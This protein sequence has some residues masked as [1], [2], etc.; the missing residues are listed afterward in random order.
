M[1]KKIITSILTGCLFV[2]GFW[3]C[4][5]NNE[6]T[7]SAGAPMTIDNFTPTEG[8]GTTEMLIT[9]SNFSA[10]SAKIKVTINGLPLAIVAVNGNQVMAVVPKRCGSGHVVVSIGN[11]SVVS[12]GIFNYKFLRKV[13][14]LA[15][16]GKAGFQNAQGTDAQFDFSS[17]AWYRSLGL[18]VDDNLNVYLADPGNH[19]IRKIDSLGNV[20]TLAGNP[21]SSGYADGQG[22]AAKF[23]IPYDVT[24]D[25]EGNVW[26]ADP[27]NWDIRKISPDGTATTWAWATQDPWAVAFDKT[28]GFVYYTG[29]NSPG[30]IYQ[31]TAQWTSTEVV[32]GLNYPAGIGFDRSG[33]LYAAI[34]GDQVVE[35]FKAGTWEGN[36]IAGTP[37]AAGYLNGSGTTAKFSYPWGLAVDAP[38]NVYVAGNGTW[39]SGTSNADQS[40]RIIEAGTWEVSTFAGSGS[41]GYVDAVG[42]A[43]SF[44]GPTGVAVDK[45][46]TVYV[47]DKNNNRIRKIISE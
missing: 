27:G 13:S 21:N 41:A 26:S 20:T 31:L 46:G 22:T 38:G 39:D 8:G 45:N 19:C 43:A 10:D 33:N 5:K 15:G 25:A 42:E 18:A 32:S 4:K 11:D 30:S 16:S 7:H 23:S 44:S 36:I 47:L 29:A 6:F 9:G 17:Q 37:G 28:T 12:T 14:T 24:V 1:I 2:T 3:S 34:N 35:Q 40:I